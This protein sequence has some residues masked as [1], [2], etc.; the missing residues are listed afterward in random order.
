MKLLLLF[1]GIILLFGSLNKPDAV[2]CSTRLLLRVY[3]GK[4]LVLRDI[5]EHAVYVHQHFLTQWSY[6]GK[7]YEGDSVSITIYTE[8]VKN[9]FP[10]NFK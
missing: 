10:A 7:I 4:K 5:Q 3:N 9:S 6:Y 8:P 1:L 2:P